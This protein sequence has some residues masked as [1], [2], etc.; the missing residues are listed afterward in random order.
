MFLIYLT[1]GLFTPQ[2]RAIAA[3]KRLVPPV[4]AL[5]AFVIGLTL[6]ATTFRFDSDHMK[7]SSLSYAIDDDAHQAFWL[8][9]NPEPDEWT[10]QFFK[11]DSTLTPLPEFL[12]DVSQKY[13]KGPAPNATLSP[14]KLEL[15]EDSTTGDLRRLRFHLSSPRK[16]PRAFM[17][18]QS[19]ME[20]IST[21]ANGMK[22]LDVSGPWRLSYDQLPE[23][24]VDIT[25]VLKPSA[26]LKIRVVDCA[27]ELPEIPGL[28]PTPQPD[29]MAVMPNTL[30]FNNSPLKSNQTLVAK[31]FNF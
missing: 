31:T 6:A 13:L 29:Y 26:P 2:L 11:N 30:D 5:L 21:E 17:F 23:S 28:N 22:L 4:L 9:C 10:A 3:P 7:F 8:S 15:L 20:V 18:A 1:L 25:L 16:A 27:Y 19:P 14:P 12:G 24:G